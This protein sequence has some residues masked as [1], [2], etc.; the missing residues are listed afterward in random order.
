MHPFGERTYYTRI[1]LRHSPPMTASDGPGDAGHEELPKE[2]EDLIVRKAEG[3]PFFVE[4]VSNRSRRLAP[5]RRAGRQYVLT[6]ATRRDPGPGHDPGCAHGAHRPSARRRR[7]RPC[8][9]LLSLAGNLPTVYWIASRTSKNSRASLQELKALELIY[10]KSLYP[11]LTYMFKHALTHD[12]ASYDSAAC[13]G[14]RRCTARRGRDRGALRG[15][16]PGAL[17]DA[18]APLLRGHA[19]G[20]GLSTT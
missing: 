5:F 2:L 20:Q 11:E 4:E 9:S 19:V 16:A 13:N 12:V 14:A 6:Q 15:S 3:N 7:R 18:G 1:V 17:R 10:E 8:N